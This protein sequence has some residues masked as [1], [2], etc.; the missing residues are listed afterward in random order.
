MIHYHGTPI[1][2]AEAAVK[3]L[4]GRHAL[5]PFNDPRQIEIAAEVAQSFILDNAAYVQWKRGITVDWSRYY[6]WAEKWLKHPG[7]DWALIPDVIEGST[8][9]NDQLLSEW[10]FGSALGVPVWHFHEPLD[11]L[12]RLAATWPRVAL[13]SSGRWAQPGRPG[14]WNRMAEAMDAICTDGQ[15]QC[16]LHGLRMLSVSI[17][18]KLPL[19]SADSTTVARKNFR[20][21]EWRGRHQ[22]HSAEIRALILAERIEAFQGAQRWE[23]LPQ[24]LALELN[25]DFQLEATT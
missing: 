15:P 12:R 7:C 5:I 4:D 18:P 11:R 1:K 14:W 13:G 9:D 24:Q 20:D 22:P 16:K 17:F 8:E 25:A 6:Q 2:P 10:P 3:S 19:T 23:G 21:S